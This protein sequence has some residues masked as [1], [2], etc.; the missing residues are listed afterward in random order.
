M[1]PTPHPPG[2]LGQQHC[3]GDSSAG[4]RIHHSSDCCHSD[5]T[6]CTPLLLLYLCPVQPPVAAPAGQPEPSA[7]TCTA[8]SRQRCMV[9]TGVGGMEAWSCFSSSCHSSTCAHVPRNDES[10][11][12]ISPGGDG[13]VP[14]RESRSRHFM[15][16][17][18]KQEGNRRA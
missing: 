12:S 16:V 13:T 6:A 2:A 4:R 1:N 11:G 8:L 3:S 15:S 17:V 14:C 9:R 7:P 5:S 18:H 10:F